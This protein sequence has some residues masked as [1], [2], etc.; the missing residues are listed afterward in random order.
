MTDQNQNDASSDKDANLDQLRAKA[1]RS[2]ELEAQNR[3]LLKREA[4]REAGIGFSEGTGKLIFDTFSA[5]EMTAE[6]VAG[7]AAGYGVTPSGDTSDPTPK[8][9]PQR[10]AEQEF[11]D[12]TQRAGSGGEP[13]GQAEDGVEAGYNAYEAERKGGARREKAAAAGFGKMLEAAQAGDSKVVY[14]QAEWRER[15][16][17]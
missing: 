1:E 15:H 2:D 16:R 10:N 8:P 6:A 4:F 3:S 7:Y 12:T 14:D 5:E 9:D 17:G 13:T 11:F